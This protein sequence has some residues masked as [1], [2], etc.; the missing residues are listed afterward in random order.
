MLIAL[1]INLAHLARQKWIIS[2]LATIGILTST[3]L[4]GGASYYTLVWLGMAVCWPC[5]PANRAKSSSPLP[6]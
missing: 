2:S 6:M 5:P 4:I 3:F 1:H